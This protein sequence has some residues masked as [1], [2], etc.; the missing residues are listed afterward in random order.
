MILE[1]ETFEKYGY[2]TIDLNLHSNKLIMVK[3]DYCNEIIPRHFKC[4]NANHKNCKKDTCCKKECTRLKRQE[5]A[6]EIL[7]SKIKIGDMFGKW[8]ILNVST[9]LTEC[10]CVCGKIKKVDVF[11]LLNGTSKSCGCFSLELRRPSMKHGDSN[12]RLY[13]TWTRMRD[14][15]N[16]IYNDSYKYYGGKGIRVCEEWSE[17]INFKNWALSNGYQ[18]GLTIERIDV[19]KNYCP[20]NC[21]WITHSENSKRAHKPKILLKNEIK[22]LKE[23]VK[24]L[25]KE[26]ETLKIQL[27]LKI[28]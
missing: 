24:K 19:D 4:I 22:E 28:I 21:E 16:N 5:V 17:F 1:Q 2:K 6:T 9:K 20:E 3:C 18:E 26:I 7:K 12:T 15:C 11:S 23:T 13:G 27:N 14:R 8:K 25:N 10:Q